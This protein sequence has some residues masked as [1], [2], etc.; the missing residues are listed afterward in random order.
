MLID[1]VGHSLELN[2]DCPKADE[3]GL[4]LLNER[5]A[6]IK[7]TEFGLWDIRYLLQLQLD[8]QAF[9]VN[10]FDKTTTLVVIDFKAGADD[11]VRLFLVNNVHHTTPC[12]HSCNSCYSW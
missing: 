3:V 11:A 4:V 10:R 9:L 12:L 1:Q 5:P 2:D 8:F 6:L 7:Q